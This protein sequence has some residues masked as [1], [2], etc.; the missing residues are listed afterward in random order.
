MQT[1]G[2]AGHARKR[3]QHSTMQVFQMVGHITNRKY[4][5][6]EDDI[7]QLIQALIISCLVHYILYLP[8]STVDLD[9]LD[10]LLQ[11]AY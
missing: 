5:H 2:G 6:K 1:N 4:G 9:T 11:T 7:L 3:L 8:L 10:R